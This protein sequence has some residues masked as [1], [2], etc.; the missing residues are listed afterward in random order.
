[1]RN[2]TL[3]Y[4]MMLFAG[5]AMPATAMALCCPGDGHVIEAARTG[6]GESQPPTR[7]ISVDPEWQVYLFER[8][9]IRYYQVNDLMGR[10]QFIAGQSN[11]RLWL[12]PSGTA[13]PPAIWNMG[14][15]SIL[16]ASI[17]RQV[18][19]GSS[20]A[21]YSGGHADDARWVIILLESPS[22]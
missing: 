8:D 2:P 4:A 15:E 19:L 18:Y 13:R 10:I 3:S 6:L 22:T 12:L 1:M 20:I 17:G 7:N 21:I 9:G 16:P 14:N 11:E 5:S